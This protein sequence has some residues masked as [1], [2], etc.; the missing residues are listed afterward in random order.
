MEQNTPYLTKRFKALENIGALDPV[1]VFPSD[2][3]DRFSQYADNAAIQ[4][5]WVSSDV[6]KLAPQTTSGA[7][8]NHAGDIPIVI[9]V[10]DTATNNIYV[11]KTVSS[12]DLT[13]YT[14]HLTLRQDAV[15]SGAW[16]FNLAS[17]ANLATNS[18]KK[19]IT[20]TSAG[21]WQH[22]SFTVASMSADNGSYAIGST[23]KLGFKCL[24][25]SA[26]PHL[27][28]D[29][30]WFEKAG[31]TYV[32]VKKTFG[33]YY[34]SFPQAGHTGMAVGIAPAAITSGNEGVIALYGLAM[35]GY[36]GLLP[37]L[38]YYADN[39]A[40]GDMTFNNRATTVITDMDGDGPIVVGQALD[41][42]TMMLVKSTPAPF[43]NP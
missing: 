28:V 29:K 6:A 26:S 5:V 17:G 3:I 19:A 14:V 31:T 8:L 25:S 10:I 9:N 38:F 37:G 20:V 36:T 22:I 11:A 34:G 12:R 41:D 33:E 43:Y 1:C 39:T 30:C 18:V 4:A 15:T 7:Q 40:A 2:L 23:V 35:D 16:Q 21:V 24:D 13:G 27:Y 32:G 42:T